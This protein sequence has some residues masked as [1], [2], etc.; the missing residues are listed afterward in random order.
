MAENPENEATRITLE[1]VMVVLGKGKRRKRIN[2]GIIED[3]K[4]RDKV[5]SNRGLDLQN[6]AKL[7]LQSQRHLALDVNDQGIHVPLERLHSDAL[8]LDFLTPQ[9]TFAERQR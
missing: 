2:G 4:D 6:Y 3:S 7:C 1:I 5:G 9:R 8:D